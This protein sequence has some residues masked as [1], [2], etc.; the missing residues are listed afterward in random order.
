MTLQ[1]RTL[2]E[3]LAD[4]RLLAL[5]IFGEAE[6]EKLIGKFAV[7][8]VIFNRARLWRKSVHD[9]CL[10]VNKKGDPDFECFADGNKRLP[11]LLKLAARWD[12]ASKALADCLTAAQGVLSGN[13]QSNVGRAT[14]YKT[15]A[16]KS[17]W[18]DKS[19][20][21]GI[22]QKCAEVG[23]HEFFMETRFKEAA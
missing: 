23:A 19:V 3:S 21:K 15:I 22:L 7:G 18:F 2:F 13:L 12:D 11:V 17:P 16:C 4:E 1:E 9:I 8:Y 14:F 20:A 10:M 5:T 6:G